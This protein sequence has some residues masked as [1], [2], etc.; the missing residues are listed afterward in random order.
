MT[1]TCLICQR[2]SEFEIIRVIGSEAKRVG[3][4]NR[5]SRARFVLQSA[6]V[7]LDLASVDAQ[8]GLVRKSNVLHSN[9]VTGAKDHHSVGF[10]VN[11]LLQ[12]WVVVEF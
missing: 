10:V 6:Q 1:A 2:I 5:S 8:L 9:A 3:D 12:R 11:A 4:V 7:R